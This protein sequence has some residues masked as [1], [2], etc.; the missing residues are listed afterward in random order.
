MV[1]MAYRVSNP[2]FDSPGAL[3]RASVAPL[4]DE[5]DEMSTRCIGLDCEAVTGTEEM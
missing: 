5:K 3:T 4:A 2:G 1:H